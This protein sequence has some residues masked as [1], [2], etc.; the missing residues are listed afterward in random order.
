LREAIDS[1][2]IQTWTD[3]EL[4]FWDNCSSDNSR[5]IV[6]SYN[7]PRIH[8][9]CAPQKITLAAGRNAV[10]DRCNGEWIAFLDCDDIW[11]EGKLE[12]QMARVATSKQNNVGLVY[13]RTRS[14]SEQGDEGDTTYRYSNRALPEG[15]I[16]QSMLS[17]GNLIPIVSAM[18]SKEAITTVG[19]IPERLTFAED[20]WLFTAIAAHFQVLCVQDICCRY[21]VHVGS[22]TYSHKLES[23]Q[24]AL[25]VVQ[26]WSHRMVPS[27]YKQRCAQY[28]TLIG[29]EHLRIKGRTLLG[30]REIFVK[31]SLP[32]LVRGAMTTLYRFWV[33]RQR[34]YS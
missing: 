1:V 20:Y 4:V 21:R 12:K 30:L 5:E 14:F 13:T 19:P 23:H 9:Y 8:F 18:I 16:L 3:W 11:L 31:G 17:E 28:Y 25:E 6:E 29:I 10:I 27:I 24:E 26:Q 2:L 22:A 7:D 34:P 32:F 15:F 33:K